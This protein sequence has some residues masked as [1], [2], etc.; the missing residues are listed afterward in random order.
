MT[1]AQERAKEARRI[2]LLYRNQRELAQVFRQ[3][4]LASG[5]EAT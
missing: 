3:Q 5:K 1:D 4:A 2:G